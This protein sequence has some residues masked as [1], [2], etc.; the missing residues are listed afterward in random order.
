MFALNR[1]PN[2]AEELKVWDTVT[3]AVTQKQEKY[4]GACQRKAQGLNKWAVLEFKINLLGARNRVGIGLLYRPARLYGL[5][6]SI[7]GLLKSLSI[8]SLLAFMLRLHYYSLE[9]RIRN[10]LLTCTST[11]LRTTGKGHT[12]QKVPVIVKNLDG[13]SAESD[14]HLNFPRDFFNIPN[15]CVCAKCQ[16][17]S[18]KD[19]QKKDNEEIEG[20]GGSHFKEIRRRFACVWNCLVSAPSATPIAKNEYR[21]FETNIPRKGI[22]RPQSQFPHHV[23][24]S[25]LNIPTIELP[26]SAA[27]NMWTDRSW[28]NINRSQTRECGYWD[29]GRAISRRGI[30]KWDFRCSAGKRN[31]GQLI[32]QK[33]RKSILLPTAFKM[34]SL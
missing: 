8:P 19:R 26:Y 6:E 3:Q 7:P 20:C 18:K 4:L 24:V 9:Q 25:Y 33:R 13:T 30:H 28:E 1:Q 5:A 15:V 2:T 27:G 12:Q 29:W 23:S 22:A 21:K 14:A 17:E 31:K 32:P 11:T 10:P 16:K 34:L